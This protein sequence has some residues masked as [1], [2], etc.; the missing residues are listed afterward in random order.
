[1][2]GA[3]LASTHGADPVSVADIRR[4]LEVVGLACPLHSDE[5]CARAHGYETIVSPVSMARVWAMPAY[6]SPGD[7]T[8][9]RAVSAPVPGSVVP[10]PGSS[11][12]ATG[13]RMEY[14]APMY[15]GD[16]LSSHAVLRSVTVKS[17]RVGDGAF[18][19]VETTYVNQRS[20][21][22]ALETATLFRYAPRSTEIEAEPA[23]RETE[24]V[25]AETTGEQLAPFGLTLTHQ[26]LVMEAGANRDFSPIHVAV[27]AARASGAPDIFANTTLVETMLEAVLRVWAGPAG[28]IRVLEFAMLAPNCVGDEIAAG[29]SVRVDRESGSGREVELDVW[30]DSSRGRTV[31]GSAVVVFPSAAA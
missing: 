5:A 19:V 1:M 9:A 29:G 14:R 3:T 16:R 7:Q 21:V 10:G 18:L 28:R 24:G 25:L 13:V 4:K 22:A 27:D 20:E 2:I 31:R 23:R 30:I 17:T 8:T 6:W 26:R 12:I 11:L 15:P